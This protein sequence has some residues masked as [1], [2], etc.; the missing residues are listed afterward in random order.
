[1]YRDLEKEVYSKANRK[2]YRGRFSDLEL[3]L[4]VDM[5]NLVCDIFRVH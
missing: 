3:E 2:V 4:Q 5:L 1:M